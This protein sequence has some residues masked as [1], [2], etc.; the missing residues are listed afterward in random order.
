MRAKTSPVT[1]R[2]KWNQ[3]HL[4]PAA[5]RILARLEHQW[6]YRISYTERRNWRNGIA[7]KKGIASECR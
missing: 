6:R 1:R 3:R 5:S 2:T 7:S 4:F